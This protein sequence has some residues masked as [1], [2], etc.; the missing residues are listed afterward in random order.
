[1][2]ATGHPAVASVVGG[3]LGRAGGITTPKNP[4]WVHWGI[5]PPIVKAPLLIS[6]KALSL[7]PYNTSTPVIILVDSIFYQLTMITFVSSEASSWKYHVS[8]PCW[9]RNHKWWGSL[10]HS[11]PVGGGELPARPASVAVTHKERAA[12]KQRR[13]QEALNNSS[14]DNRMLKPNLQR[15]KAV[16]RSHKR[17]M[18]SPL[19]DEKQHR[20][21]RQWRR[22]KGALRR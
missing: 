4:L 20:H 11:A 7:C 9:Q 1:M 16:W 2:C 14:K 8:W 6:S 10:L 22:N 21:Y 12:E 19:T 17:Q 15:E 18:P 13:G 5:I 3:H